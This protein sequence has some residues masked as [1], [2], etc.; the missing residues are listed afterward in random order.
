MK[1]PATYEVQP[2]TG[3]VNFT[4]RV[5]GSKSLTNRALILA[6]HADEG[7]TLTGALQSED[8]EVMVE[9]LRQLG[10]EVTTDWEQATISVKRPVLFP[11]PLVGEGLGVRGKPT[12]QKLLDTTSVTPHPQPLSHKGRGEQDTR[13]FVGNSGTTIRFLTA[14]LATMHGHFRL[15][16]IPRMRERPIQDLLD[17]LTQLGVN[18]KS[19]LGTG[20]PPVLLE[21]NGLHGG[22]V[23]VKADTSSQFLSGLLMA[24]PFATADTVVEIAGDLVSEPYI[25]MTVA[26]M[27]QFGLIL[28]EVA[29]GRYVVPGRQSHNL[30]HYAIEPDASSASYFFAIAA[31]TGGSAT[32][33]GLTRHSLQGDVKFVDALVRMGCTL[34]ETDDALTI[35]GTDELKGINIDMNAISDTVMTLAVVALFAEE[36]TWIYNVAHIRHKETDRLSALA[37]ELRKFGASVEEYPD[38]LKITPGVLSGAIVDTYNDHRMAMSLALVGLRVPGV[39]VNDPGCV[40]KTYPGFWADFEQVVATPQRHG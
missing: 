6:A 10:W 16:G 38:G 13:L 35:T 30:S 14:M 24:V 32:L 22:A 1:Y 15:D 7:C 17:A 34:T 33:T 21:A 25:T 3:P 28:E 18:A 9:C 2:V 29:P 40:V 39:V 11:S 37:T 12:S 26:M 27:R 4:L 20:C 36:P 8:T 19:E 5:P 23:R 31:I